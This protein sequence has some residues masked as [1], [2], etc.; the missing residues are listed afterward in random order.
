MSK[1]EEF[2]GKLNKVKRIGGDRF[3]ACCPAHNDS[4]P[5]LS[6]SYVNNRIMVKCWAGC[7]VVDVVSAVGLGMEDLFDNHRYDYISFEGDFEDRRMAI[8]TN[9]LIEQ[10]VI[11]LAITNNAIEDGKKLTVSEADKA[12]KAYQYLKRHGMLG[13][14]RTFLGEV[15]V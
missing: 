6:V 2:L 7:N 12:N 1:L 15:T 5:S 3:M 13:E 11:R 8:K 10:A 9:V 4:S 14:I